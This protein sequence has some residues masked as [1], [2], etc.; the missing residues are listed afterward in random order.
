MFFIDLSKVS[1]VVIRAIKSGTGEGNYN[2]EISHKKHTETIDFS[3]TK[4]LG[5]ETV[6]PY[7]YVK[8]E[9][10]KQ[11]KDTYSGKYKVQ[12]SSTP[13]QQFAEKEFPAKY[14]ES[15][16]NKCKQMIARKEILGSKII[17]R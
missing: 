6:L 3:Q 13:K 9:H 8:K 16:F 11:G 4:K 1:D 14:A 17:V 10:D 12:I 5:Q 2:I 15:L 7:F